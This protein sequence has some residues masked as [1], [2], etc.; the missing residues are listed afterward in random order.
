M[1][2]DFHTH[3]YPGKIL[4]KVLPTVG[5]SLPDSVFTDGTEEGLLAS[6]KQSGID[7]SVTL[8]VATHVGQV[9]KLNQ[10]TLDK[11]ESGFSKGLIHF[12]CMHPDYEDYKKELKRLKDGGVLGIKLHPLYYDYTLDD[13]RYLRII[14]CASE[15]G[16]ITLTHTG[17]DP[18]FM[19][20]RLAQVDHILNVID[21][22]HPENFVLAHL[23]NA[24]FMA[25]TEEYLVGAP[26]YMDLGYALIFHGEKDHI[27]NQVP[28]LTKVTK[29]R[30]ERIIRKHGADRIL[31][32][33]DSPWQGQ[34][35]YLDYFAELDLTEEERV[36][37]LGKSA[38]KLLHI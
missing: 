28:G 2:I 20:K 16:L 30:I 31:F 11:R 4:K 19:D 32:A 34:Q 21:Q 29:D 3:T 8:P 18:L 7:Y 27:V 35:Q 36:K 22:V 37:V 12:G 15:L 26:V 1:I 10:I 14:D 25:H 13:I 33:T 6:M 17:L 24:G 9:E 38:K 5:G 23:G